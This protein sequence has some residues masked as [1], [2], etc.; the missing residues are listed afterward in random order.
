MLK[1]KSKAGSITILDF[2]LYYEAVII[3]KVWY[4]HKNR[5]IH[6]WDRIENQIC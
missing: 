3:K 5:H 4:W 2:K 6:E 1:K